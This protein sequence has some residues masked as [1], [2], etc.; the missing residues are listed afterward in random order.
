MREPVERRDARG[1]VVRLG[2][3]APA[4]TARRPRGRPTAG[5]ARSSAS[6][7]SAMSGSAPSSMATSAL[8]SATAAASRLF[9][10]STPW[11]AA[12]ASTT[13]CGAPEP[14]ASEA[15]A[16]AWSM[17][18]VARSRRARAVPRGTSRASWSA[19]SSPKASGRT[20]LPKSCSRPPGSSRAGVAAGG[21]DGGARAGDRQRVQVHLAAHDGAVAGHRLQEAV[22]AGLE[23]ELADAQP[24]DHDDRL[25][26]ALRLQRPRGGGGVH[27]AE[28]VRGEGAVRL[29]GRHDVARRGV[30]IVGQRDDARDRPREHRQRAESG[31]RGIDAGR[32]RS[33][34]AGF[35]VDTAVGSLPRFRRGGP[36]RP[37]IGIGDAVLEYPVRTSEYEALGTHDRTSTR[38][39]AAGGGPRRRAG[40]RRL[41]AGFA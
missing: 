9:R 5:R 36:D 21:G 17:P 29:D 10:G 18:N 24:A 15:P 3:A 35:A 41:R 33:P 39:T 11:W 16:T 14:G 22:G 1:D 27:V 31:H 19:A 34:V 12:M 8:P 7:T 28:Q 37:L 30:G 23:R 4:P 2:L 40:R 20:S 38:A 13:T 25:A 32:A 26:H 6:S